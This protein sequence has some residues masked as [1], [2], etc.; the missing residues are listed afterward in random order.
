MNV[1]TLNDVFFS[2]VER[3]SDRVMLTHE[4]GTWTPI[5]AAQLQ[6]R[7]FATARQLQAWDIGKGDRVAL[8][9]ENR[10]E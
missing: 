5:S 7:V 8:L 6:A 1:R 10:P 4:S 3:N 9:S 2:I